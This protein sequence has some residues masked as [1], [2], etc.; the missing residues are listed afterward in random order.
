MFCNCFSQFVTQ[1]L[2]RTRALKEYL[3][4][5]KP[6]G[7]IGLAEMCK[8]DEIPPDLL[9]KI[10]E[11]EEGLSE[12]TGL[13]LEFSTPSQWRNWLENVGIE[14]IRTEKHSRMG[15]GGL[16]KM[17]GRWKMTKIIFKTIYHLLFNGAVRK[18]MK[19]VNKA[20]RVLMRNKETK[21]RTGILVVV[22]K[23]PV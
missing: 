13:E 21:K 10:I 4:V 19:P 11:A 17:T 8:D 2:E 23:R 14:D 20:K 16:I 1:F 5:V 12:A 7:F 22:G 6:G 3:R 18:R 9:E 15:V